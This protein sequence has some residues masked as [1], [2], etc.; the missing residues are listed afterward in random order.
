M[1]RIGAIPTTRVP[2]FV[3]IILHALRVVALFRP[4][5]V[6]I[7][8]KFAQIAFL[9]PLEEYLMVLFTRLD[10]VF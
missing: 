10:E 9:Y 3:S 4:V 5:L 2:I 7:I 1:E 8:Y 6:E